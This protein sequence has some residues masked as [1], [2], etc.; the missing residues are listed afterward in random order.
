MSPEQLVQVY[1]LLERKINSTQLPAEVQG[2]DNLA[3]T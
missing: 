1:F 3:L 2:E